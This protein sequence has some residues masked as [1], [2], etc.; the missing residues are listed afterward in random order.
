MATCE[1]CKQGG[2]KKTFSTPG[3]IF[4]YLKGS[5]LICDQCLYKAITGEHREWR[6]EI[7]EHITTDRG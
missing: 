7:A 6:D 2:V 3:V 4:N 1:I 5:P